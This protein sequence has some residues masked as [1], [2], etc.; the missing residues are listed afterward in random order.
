MKKIICLAVIMLLVGSVAFAQAYGDSRIGAV[1]LNS[2]TVY[3]VQTED[4]GHTHVT[5]GPTAVYRITY[6]SA[7]AGTT[8]AL[9][10]SN[11]TSTYASTRTMLDYMTAPSKNGNSY[12]KTCVGAAAANTVYQVT[13]DPPLQFNY[14]VLVGFPHY[15]QGAND[16]S[17]VTVEYRQN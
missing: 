17:S 16:A 4:Y 6:T 12:V 2:K 9:Y 15:L 11:T 14:G 13:Y 10:D 1:K 8:V 5:V 7:K 3:N